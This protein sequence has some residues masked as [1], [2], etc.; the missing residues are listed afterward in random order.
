MLG[1]V[2]VEPVNIGEL[3]TTIYNHF[4][5]YLTINDNYVSSFITL[6]YYGTSSYCINM[7]SHLGKSWSTTLAQ[8]HT[9]MSDSVALGMGHRL[10]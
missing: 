3:Y 4:D 5:F 1:L 6:H 8:R 9:V 10:L 2:K 7:T